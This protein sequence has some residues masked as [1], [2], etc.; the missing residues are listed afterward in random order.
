M[1]VV[2]ALGDL[3]MLS[4]L[5]S[6]IATWTHVFLLFV[7]F[8]TSLFHWRCLYEDFRC[9][10]VQLVFSFLYFCRIS[11]ADLTRLLTKIL[12]DPPF[13]V[14]SEVKC[15]YL[16][17]CNLYASNIFILHSSNFKNF[18]DWRT[19]QAAMPCAAHINPT[20]LSCMS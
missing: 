5:L 18:I 17:V 8:W 6:N 19:M 11:T 7:Y 12:D 15:I 3:D 16:K 9:L 2:F 10:C 1:N 13:D 14:F 20:L 4:N